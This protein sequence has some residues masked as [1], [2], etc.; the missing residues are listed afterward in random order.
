MKKSLI[1]MATVLLL[2][3]GISGCKLVT[4][5]GRCYGY[6]GPIDIRI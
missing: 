3:G 6:C 4:E 2:M 1:R 5:D